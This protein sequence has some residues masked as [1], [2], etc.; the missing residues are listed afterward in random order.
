MSDLAVIY[1]SK[2]ETDRQTD[3]DKKKTGSHN[4]IVGWPKDLSLYLPL[5][6]QQNFLMTLPR[7][8]AFVSVPLEG[9]QHKNHGNRN[10]GGGFSKS[11][12][13]DLSS[14]RNFLCL[15]N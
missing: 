8:Q 2:A 9:S 14:G 12:E 11:D 4:P 13:Y 6:G 10:R 5:E 1:L 7:N 15:D 3:R